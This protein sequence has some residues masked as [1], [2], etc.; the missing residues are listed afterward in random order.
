MNLKNIKKI[1]R[2]AHR[3]VMLNLIMIGVFLI[4]GLA[5]AAY[6]IIRG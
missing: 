2:T 5:I 1:N 6:Q 3:S 4:I